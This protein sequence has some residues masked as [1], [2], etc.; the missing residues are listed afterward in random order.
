MRWLD[1]F[2]YNHPKFAIPN[3]M[4]YI[5][6]GNVA[7]WLLDLV[8]SGTFS[9][10]IDFVP[11]LIFRGQVWRLVSFVFIPDSYEP[12]WF[13]LSCVLYYFLGTQLERAWGSAR[14]TLFYL[15]GVSLT[16]ISGLLLALGGEMWPMMTTASMYYVNMSMFLAFATLYPDLE[17]RVMF[18]LPIRGKWL[19]WI[20]VAM[21]AIDVWRSFAA[22]VWLMALAPLAA[23]VNY[24]LFF[25]SDL[26]L[27]F[28]RGK[29]VRRPDPVTRP[30]DMKAAK[31]H[32]QQKQGYLHKCTVCGR[33]DTDNPGLE[34]RYCSRCSGYHCYCMDHIN[35][36]A[37]I[38]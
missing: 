33:T 31:K 35:D 30:V 23:L 38:Q 32:V 29:R 5:V 21:I 1:R 14:F 27:H 22:R 3:L 16:A 12:I 4:K 8:S 11:G 18:I 17:F 26:V 24:A 2:G 9:R 15:F 7:V 19:A 28:E 36:H 37:H 20:Y 10:L 13:V 34:F 25:W 6:F